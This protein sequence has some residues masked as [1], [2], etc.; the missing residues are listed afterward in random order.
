MVT[1]MGAFPAAAMAATA[2]VPY[3]TSS[4]LLNVPAK[5][6]STLL[7]ALGRPRARIAPSSRRSPA[8]RGRSSMMQR[9]WLL[10]L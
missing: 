6:L 9:P 4:R 1:T 10:A 3:P 2:W 8:Y 5:P 7:M